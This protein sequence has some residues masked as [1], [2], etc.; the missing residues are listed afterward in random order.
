MT[1]SADSFFAAVCCGLMFGSWSSL[2]FSQ[3]NRIFSYMLVLWCFCIN[4][5]IYI[6]IEPFTKDAPRLADVYVFV[7]AAF[8]G[9]VRASDC[10][11]ALV[12]LA[13][14][15]RQHD[16]WRQIYI[17]LRNML[18][19]YWTII[20]GGCPAVVCRAYDGGVALF[21]CVNALLLRRA[22]LHTFYRSTGKR[23][24]I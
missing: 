11:F 19:Q 6:C 2:S 5:N 10:L 4:I 8:I 23:S 7:C 14:R 17:C 9:R 12:L 16:V 18:G 20:F 1:T 22:P 3:A 13:A 15:R 24:C 21:D